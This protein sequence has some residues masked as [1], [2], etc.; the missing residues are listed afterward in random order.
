MVEL[1]GLHRL[2]YPTG[3]GETVEKG[4]LEVPG[5]NRERN[6]GTTRCPFDKDRRKRMIRDVRE[7]PLESVM[8]DTRLLT[9][10]R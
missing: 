1:R 6:F 7:N 8:V 5:R 2:C 10:E 9:V 3:D 4:S